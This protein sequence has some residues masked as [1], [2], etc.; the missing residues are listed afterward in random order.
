MLLRIFSLSII[1]EVNKTIIGYVLKIKIA[2]LTSMY[3]TESRSPDVNR[4]DPLVNKINVQ[5]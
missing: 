4:I 3:L 5:I 2:K 1:T